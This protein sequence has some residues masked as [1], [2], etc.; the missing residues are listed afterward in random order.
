MTFTWWKSKNKV[1]RPIKIPKPQKFKKCLPK[2]IPEWFSYTTIDFFI[3][4]IFS[5]YSVHTDVFKKYCLWTS[6]V[7]KCSE[8]DIG[9]NCFEIKCIGKYIISLCPQFCLLIHSSAH[10]LSEPNQ[11]LEKPNKVTKIVLNLR[12]SIFCI[13]TSLRNSW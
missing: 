6:F 7:T 2:K 11:H 10:K 8:C 4:K 9:L 3:I 12:A 13:E 1:F 5:D